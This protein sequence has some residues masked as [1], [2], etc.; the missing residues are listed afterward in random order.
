MSKAPVGEMEM[1]SKGE[2]RQIE[3]DTQ[4]RKNYSVAKKRERKRGG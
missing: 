3:E 4:R 1:L 2:K